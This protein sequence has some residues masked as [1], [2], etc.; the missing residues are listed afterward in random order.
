[1]A[2][3]KPVKRKG[4]RSET[5]REEGRRQIRNDGGWYLHIRRERERREQEAKN[6]SANGREKHAIR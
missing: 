6:I 5:Q 2:I 1:M 3:G 4:N